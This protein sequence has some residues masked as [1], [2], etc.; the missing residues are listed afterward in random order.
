MKSVTA[1]FLGT[2]LPRTSQG[3]LIL[4][5]LYCIV[6]ISFGVYCVFYYGCFNLFCNVEVF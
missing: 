2:K 6:T 4:R 3:D 5:L 1:K